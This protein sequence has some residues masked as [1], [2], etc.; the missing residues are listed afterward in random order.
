MF[1]CFFV[2]FPIT[3]CLVISTPHPIS[4]Q[5]SVV[6][7]MTQRLVPHSASDWFL[8][9]NVRNITTLPSNT[10]S[11]ARDGSLSHVI[12]MRNFSSGR[13]LHALQANLMRWA[14]RLKQ[15]RRTFVEKIE[16][17]AVILEGFL[18]Y[19]VVKQQEQD[20]LLVYKL[21]YEVHQVMI[22]RTFHLF[23]QNIHLHYRSL[24]ESTASSKLYKRAR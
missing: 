15:T 24:I 7:L 19:S 13:I 21:P 22:N 12:S 2:K 17:R 14:R 5:I 3:P 1:G 18:C 8:H 11:E 20:C 23:S 16:Y 10:Q 9:A 6:T 4:F